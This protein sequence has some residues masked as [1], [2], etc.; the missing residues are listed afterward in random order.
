MFF[1]SK[2]DCI[3]IDGSIQLIALMVELDHGFVNCDVIR[4][5][6]SNRM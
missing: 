1:V 6:S 5:F 3:R 4:L 2:Y